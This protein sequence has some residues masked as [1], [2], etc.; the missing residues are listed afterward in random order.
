MSI[1]PRV[2][3]VDDE[4]PLCMVLK[5]TLEMEGYDVEICSDAD[6]ARQKLADERFD[7][8]MLDVYLTDEPLGIELGRD[9]ISKY[10]ST[11][12]VFMT[13]YALEDDIRS[14][15]ESGA[16]TCIRKPYMLDDVIRVVSTSVDAAKTIQ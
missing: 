10:P 15:I 13:G 9:V 8:A 12:L 16:F 1:A 6:T 2:L 7:V 4:L 11:S 14:G 5:D 3:V